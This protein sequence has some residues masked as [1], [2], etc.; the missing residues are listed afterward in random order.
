MLP[1]PWAS[2]W[3]PW[4]PCRSHLGGLLPD[5]ASSPEPAPS[6]GP[7]QA[8]PTP[9]GPRSRT[10]AHNVPEGPAHRCSGAEWT[11]VTWEPCAP[12]CPVLVST[13]Q[14]EGKP[15][16]KSGSI[17]PGTTV[18]SLQSRRGAMSYTGH[19]VTVVPAAGATARGGHQPVQPPTGQTPGRRRGRRGW[20]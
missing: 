19:Q 10:A 18:S 8:T 3:F 20:L 1:P 5:T 12:L 11:L 16:E 13:Q 7:S 14:A 4:F 6:Q 17:P 9:R 15:T 2:V